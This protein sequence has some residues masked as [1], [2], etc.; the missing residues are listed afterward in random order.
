MVDVHQ[1]W[2]SE[3]GWKALGLHYFVHQDFDQHPDISKAF[4]FI[5]SARALGP[6]IGQT[7]VQ[8][9]QNTNPLTVPLVEGVVGTIKGQ[10]DDW[11]G[12]LPDG[13]KG[14]WSQGG[15]GSARFVLTLDIDVMVPVPLLGRIPIQV[16][17]FHKPC[18][19]LLHFDAVKKR[20]VYMPAAQ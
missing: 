14:S 1:V 19:V 11:Q 13:K 15:L 6:Q 10:L 16:K 4:D 20:Y 8:P 18:T 7:T 5:I 3:D 9:L 17:G 2:Q 12:Y